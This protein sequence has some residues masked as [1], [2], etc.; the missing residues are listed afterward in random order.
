MN[1]PGSTAPWPSSSLPCRPVASC[2]RTCPRAH[3]RDLEFLLWSLIFSVW[4][5]IFLVWSLIFDLCSPP[6]S[7]YTSRRVFAISSLISGVSWKFSRLIFNLWFPI[8][9]SL[10]SHRSLE[11][12]YPLL[13]V[14]HHG[15]QRLEVGR[16]VINLQWVSAS[17]HILVNCY[18]VDRG[19]KSVVNKKTYSPN[20][21]TRYIT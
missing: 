17:P 6:A 15:S 10:I 2:T 7:A 13:D 3:R 12:L 18:F 11:G 1:S 20:E 5:L 9:W 14:F 21:N 4:S 16:S 19:A 8:F